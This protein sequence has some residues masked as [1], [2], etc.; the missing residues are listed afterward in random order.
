MTRWGELVATKQL[1]EGVIGDIDSIETVMALRKRLLDIIRAENSRGAWARAE[2]VRRLLDATTGITPIDAMSAESLGQLAAARKFSKSFNDTFTRGPL[3]KILGY[4][5]AGDVRI[6]PEM[7]YERL[8]GAGT[9]GQSG[10]RAVRQAAAFDPENAAVSVA[11][12]DTNMSKYL[13]AKFAA[14]AINPVTGEF[15]PAAASSFIKQYGPTLDEFTA[16]RDAMI[17]ATGAEQLARSVSTSARTRARRIT[18]MSRA[19]LYTRGEPA[20]QMVSVL[21]SNN[22][23]TAARMIMHAAAKDKTGVATLGV[24]SA[25]YE[26]M[27]ERIAPDTSN[28]LDVAGGTLIQAKKLRAF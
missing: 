1:S 22:P 12:F 4:D 16:L 2:R 3:G 11:R 20:A 13:K 14:V 18:A 5:T 19:A 27:M 24:R 8:L 7:T 23:V 28:T 10:V 9:S 15:S 25:L 21:N 17:D 26:A 6:P